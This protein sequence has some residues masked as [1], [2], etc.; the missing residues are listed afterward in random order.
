VHGACGSRPLGGAARDTSAV[1]CR[2]S[3]ARRPGSP[4]ANAKVLTYVSRILT[5]LDPRDRVQAVVS[6]YRAGLVG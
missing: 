2:P 6:A 4:A 5:E 3:A 1:G